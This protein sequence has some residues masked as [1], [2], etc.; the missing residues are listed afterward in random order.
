MSGFSL[1]RSSLFSFISFHLIF[2]IFFVFFASGT[3]RLISGRAGMSSTARW[4]FISRAAASGRQRSL[5]III[6]LHVSSFLFLRFIFYFFVSFVYADIVNA[7]NVLLAIV[8][9]VLFRRVFEP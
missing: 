3:S 5:S 2:I 6:E 7:A 8:Y 9:A 1:A 4:Q